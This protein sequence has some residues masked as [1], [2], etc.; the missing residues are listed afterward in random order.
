MRVL[1][2]VVSGALACAL[3]S[4]GGNRV[5]AVSAPSAS[6]E[7]VAE[8]I[9]SLPT[10]TYD[11][12][13]DVTISS[14]PG[15]K[16]YFTTDGSLPSEASRVYDGP[17]SVTAPVELKAIATVDGDSSLVSTAEYV[18]DSG[19]ASLSGLPVPP[20]SGISRPNGRLR[21]L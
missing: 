21:V 3:S 15:A 10:G 16:I 19:N 5:I 11:S 12:A 8:P 9:F 7:R 18:I 6:S 4:C 20:A 14:A 17:L 13:Q 1:R 2:I